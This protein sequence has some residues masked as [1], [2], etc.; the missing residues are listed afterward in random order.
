MEGNPATHTMPEEPENEQGVI[1]LAHFEIPNTL[2]RIEDPEDP[3]HI[4]FV[5][6]PIETGF[7]HTLGNSCAVCS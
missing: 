1:Q 3:N 7:G 5:A 2:K 6:E 4:T